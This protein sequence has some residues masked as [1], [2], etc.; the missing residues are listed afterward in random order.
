MSAPRAEPVTLVL[1]VLL[2]GARLATV[3]VRMP[4]D[5]IA[6]TESVAKAVPVDAVLSLVAANGDDHG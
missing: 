3:R 5:E 1:V 6:P 2:D 4:G